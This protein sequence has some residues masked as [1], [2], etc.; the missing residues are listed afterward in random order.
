MVAIRGAQAFD[1]SRQ[2][3]FMEI[4]VDGKT[5][6]FTHVAPAGLTGADLQKYVDGQESFYIDQIRK[7]LAVAPDGSTLPEHPAS[8]ED[9]AM[10][11]L[12]ARVTATEEKL[13]VL[14]AK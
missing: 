7:N 6:P 13:T 10:T 5:W 4:E 12:K 11:D 8:K 14:M 1:Q 3:V 2:W 9:P